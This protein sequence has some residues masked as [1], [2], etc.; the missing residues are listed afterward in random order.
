MKI[1]DKILGGFS[2]RGG[3]T[4]P[5]AALSI[6]ILSL[7]MV[8]GASMVQ[9]KNAAD[10]L[11]TT[12]ENMSAIVEA[13]TSY[14]NDKKHLP[15]PAEPSYLDSNANFGIAVDYDVENNDCSNG[16]ITNN[17]GMVPVRTLKLKDDIAFDGWD[18][19]FTYRI[20]DNMGSAADFLRKENKGDIEILDRRGVSKTR[21]HEPPPH[22]DGAV[23]VL[24]SHGKN[25]KDVAWRRG[26][27]TAPASATGLEKAN[28]SHDQPLYMQSEN[29]SGFDDIVTF[30][31]KQNFLPPR[32]I[33]APIKIDELTCDNAKAITNAGRAILDDFANSAGGTS[34]RADLIYKAAQ[35]ISG[36]CESKPTGHYNPANMPEL[37]LW[38][39]ADDGRHIYTNSDCQTGALPSNSD[40]VGCWADKSGNG[41][42][43]TA[44]SKPTYIT[45]AANGKPV[46]SFN[47]GS[48]NY[49]TIAADNSLNFSDYSYDIITIMKRDTS[50]TGHVFEHRQTSAPNPQYNLTINTTG[51]QLRH[52]MSQKTNP[53]ALLTTTGLTNTTDFYIVNIHRT[54]TEVT[55]YVNGESD[56]SQ[57]ISSGSYAWA[58]TPVN[59]GASRSDHAFFSGDL[60]EVIFFSRAIQTRERKGLERYLSDKWG[61][62]LAS[63][64]D[65]L[66]APGLVFRKSKENPKGGCQCEEGKVLVHELVSNNAC[67]LGANTAFS[68]C[69]AVDTPPVYP[70]PPAPKGMISW[71]DANDCS[72]VILANGSQSL[73]RE[74][75][76]KSPAGAFDATQGSTSAQPSY[77]KNA[78]NDKPVM[79]FD[80]SSDYFNLPSLSSLTAGEVFVVLKKVWEDYTGYNTGLFHL[81]AETGL[82]GASHYTWGR[83]ISQSFGNNRRYTVG[84]SQRKYVL[85]NIYNISADSSLITSRMDGVELASFPPPHFFNMSNSPKI[86]ADAN[87]N[88][89]FYGD[90]P[91]FI[92][93]NRKISPDDRND[94]HRYLA[95]KWGISLDP[96]YVPERSGTYPDDNISTNLKLWL[97]SSDSST[98]KEA[99]SCGGL[100]PTFNG[101]I[102]C[103]KDKSGNNYHAKQSDIDSRPTYSYRQLNDKNV[104]QLDGVDDKF[105]SSLN[106]NINVIPNL[107]IF[108]L[109]KINRLNAN[110]ALWGHDAGWDRFLILKWSPG[111]NSGLSNGSS[112]PVDVPELRSIDTW[113]IVTSVLQNGV[114]NGSYVY[115]N[116]VQKSNFTENQDSG[117]TTSLSIGSI[118]PQ[119]LSGI[120]AVTFAEF[121]AYDAHLTTTDRQSIE[122]YLGDK[123]GINLP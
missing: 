16:S 28:T 75:S 18:R 86:G 62:T 64:A 54:P 29:T 60:G 85:P 74:W 55:Y 82:G 3:Y 107:T 11:R 83:N 6:G 43:A 117:G 49:M 13:L 118:A 104:I 112:V 1:L 98:V 24:I 93:Y 115:V 39:D 68:G 33:V 47:S 122:G 20:A 51:G 46:L 71:L 23:F 120:S 89:F 50:N 72:T 106:I 103:W 84:E 91:E 5:E 37:V 73:V 110:N 123:W 116:G 81:G 45:N 26:D 113:Q 41:N 121:I 100:A 79:R 78:M 34:D 53:D 8:F 57:S 27:T 111:V 88:Y 17:T 48:S 22:N 70:K 76:D 65:S 92:L 87:T 58:A 108:T 36:M 19:K 63:A 44:T 10:A 35:K 32:N 31:L 25:G 59:I 109:H 2:K 94:V 67:Y 90:M 95:D 42:N 40:T 15:C 66:C 30:G 69:I 77:V 12:D 80:G 97:D 99:S 21:L 96:S 105:V 61:I 119:H 9:K 4:F 7:L 56:G 101:K 52:Y 38:L 102:G 114:S 14:V